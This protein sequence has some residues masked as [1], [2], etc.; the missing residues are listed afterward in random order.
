MGVWMADVDV[1]HYVNTPQGRMKLVRAMA[2]LGEVQREMDH[3]AE[4]IRATA[5][6]KLAAHIHEG[7]SEILPV[8]RGDVDRFVVLSDQRGLRAAWAIEKGNKHG[9]GNVQALADGM[10]AAVVAAMGLAG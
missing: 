6:A 4:V 3:V 8:E 10:A 1:F 9:G 2:T 7:D 5:T